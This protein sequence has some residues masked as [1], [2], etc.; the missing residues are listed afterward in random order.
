[1]GRKRIP[2]NQRRE[3]ISLSLK[4]STIDL[5]DSKI[6]SSQSRSVFVENILLKYLK[7]AQVSSDGVT[8]IRDFWDCLPC[9]KEFSK[10]RPHSGQM[11]CPSCGTFLEIS[12]SITESV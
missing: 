9:S 5:I 10:L 4:P 12:E 11:L 8:V 3:V 1:M 2:K 7:Q 6:S